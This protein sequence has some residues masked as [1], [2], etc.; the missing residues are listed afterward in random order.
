MNSLNIQYIFRI[1]FMLCLVVVT[2]VLVYLYV[3]IHNIETYIHDKNDN[4][5]LP[6]IENDKL[7]K[8]N[9]NTTPANL[10]MQGISPHID[11]K[12][13]IEAEAGTRLLRI[14]EI[15]ISE[16]KLLKRD[17]GSKN[18]PYP[19]T[20]NIVTIGVGRSLQTNGI[21]V[22]E[23]YAIVKN[24]DHKYIFENTYVKNG[25]VYISS[26]QVAKQIF[27]KPLS[28][29]DIELLLVNDLKNTTKDAINIFGQY[30]KD[31]SEPRREA[32]IDVIFN[33]GS[34]HFR[35]FHK[36]I[37]AIKEQNWEKASDE[38]LLS[39]AARNHII[40]YHRNASVI[41]TGNPK[42]FELR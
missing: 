38:L 8:S 4:L 12:Q 23:L 27:A 6:D 39:E 24:L 14:S 32:I 36:F 18:T 11:I 35:T 40:R 15:I 2:I 20:K 42:Y 37:G 16:A 1:I 10:P 31:L 28:E 41:R 17:E 26:L 13:Q 33:L 25:R 22:D 19:D 5:I 3:S 34:T 30:W 29:Y 21:S 7:E 9:D